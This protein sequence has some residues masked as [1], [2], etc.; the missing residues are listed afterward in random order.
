[1]KKKAAL[2]VVATL[3]TAPVFAQLPPLPVPLPSLPSLPSLP[4]PPAA[5]GSVT[6]AA[7]GTGVVVTVDSTQ[8]P[9]VSVTPIGLPPLPGL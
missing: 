1:M 7:N 3:F 8:T 5:S 2:A 9:P 6:V 4:A